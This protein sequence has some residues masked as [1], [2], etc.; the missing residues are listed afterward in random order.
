MRPSSTVKMSQTDNVM[1]RKR[2][3][4]IISEERRDAALN[5]HWGKSTKMQN[6]EMNT[7][8]KEICHARRQ[9]V[10]GMSKSQKALLAARIH[11]KGAARAQLRSSCN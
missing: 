11:C 4:Q 6:Q 3:K 5:I 10:A 1:L 2:K 7:E 8:R 9:E